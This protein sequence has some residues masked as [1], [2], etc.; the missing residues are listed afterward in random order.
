MATLTTEKEEMGKV[1]KA[2]LETH[3]KGA[4]EEFIRRNERGQRNYL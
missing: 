2:I 3:L 4:V 1:V